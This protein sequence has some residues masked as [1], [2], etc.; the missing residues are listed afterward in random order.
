MHRTRKLLKTTRP[1]VLWAALLSAGCGGAET[2]IPITTS[3]EEARADLISGRA[4]T[5][6]LRLLEAREYFVQAREKDPRFALAFLYAAQTATSAA[7]GQRLLRRAVGL[8]SQVSEGERWM[9]LA[10]QAGINDDRDKRVALM[11]QL[12]EKYPKDK[13]AHWL[14]G[15]AYG[16]DRSAESL[17]EMKRAVKLDQNYAPAIN[18]LGYLY[19]NKGE[20]KKSEKAFDKYIKLIPDEANP[21]DSMADLYTAMGQLEKANEFYA[22]AFERNAKFTISLRK[23][24][25]N[26]LFLRQ[27]DQARD[28]LRRVLDL[29]ETNNDRLADMLLIGRS[30]M[31]EGRFAEALEPFDEALAMAKK[32]NLPQRI[33]QMHYLKWMVHWHLGALVRADELVAAIEEDIEIYDYTPAFLNHVPNALVA[34]KTL[35]AIAHDDPASAHRVIEDFQAALAD[36][37]Q[38]GQEAYHSAM[39]AVAYYQGDYQASIEHGEQGGTD[40]AY[41]FYHRALAHKQLGQIDEARKLLDK[42][43]HWNKDS[44][45]YPLIRDDAVAALESLE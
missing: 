25:L 44:D 15:L 7:E 19:F 21:Y 11:E 40:S 6:N 34:I 38:E 23:I 31:Y 1:Y 35:M 33:L 12:V 17:A 26:Q 28:N 27:Y 4:L 29:E 20:Y 42:V 37:D 30:Y 32:A 43:A 3:S 13:R 2:T 39:F 8:A 16:N 9:I 22:Q 45:L 41:L 5:D 14:L 24:A 36:D 10:Q 18:N